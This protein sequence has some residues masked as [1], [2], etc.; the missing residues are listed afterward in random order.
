M[1][2]QEKPYGKKGGKHFGCHRRQ[3]RDPAKI[4]DRERRRCHLRDLSG[5]AI[6]RAIRKRSHFSGMAQGQVQNSEPRGADLRTV[7]RAEENGEGIHSWM[8]HNGDSGCPWRGS[9]FRRAEAE[10]APFEGCLRRADMKFLEGEN[11]PPVEG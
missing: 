1:R 2:G 6:S 9:L 10:M 8:L 3:S 5:G 4:F 11:W 7:R